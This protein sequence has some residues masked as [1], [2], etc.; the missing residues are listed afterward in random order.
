MFSHGQSVDVSSDLK[1]F[2]LYSCF[3]LV[4]IYYEQITKKTSSCKFCRPLPFHTGSLTVSTS[5]LPWCMSKHGHTLGNGGMHS[6]CTSVRWK[7]ITW[8]SNFHLFVIYFFAS[9]SQNEFVIE[10]L[11]PYTPYHLHD[12]Q[13]YSMFQKERCVHLHTPTWIRASVWYY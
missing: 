11:H 5:F 3:W 10:L 4:N 6:A 9:I 1:S 7:Q 2:A 8:W 12:F 13:I